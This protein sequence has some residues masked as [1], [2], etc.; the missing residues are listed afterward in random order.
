[1]KYK[2][3][4]GQGCTSFYTEI[5]GKGLG[6][7]YNVMTNEEVDEF[8]D[9]LCQKFKEEYR[10]STVSLDDLIRCFQSD[11]YESDKHPCETCGDTFSKEIWVFE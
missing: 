4:I 8:I 11:S 5:N 3:E 9:Y 1:M 6:G 7:E 10:N 2:V